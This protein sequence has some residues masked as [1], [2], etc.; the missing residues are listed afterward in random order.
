[1]SL[2]TFVYAQTSELEERPVVAKDFGLISEDGDTLYLYED[3][4]NQG[5][6]VLLTFFG[7]NCVTCQN[8][9]SKLNEIFNEYNQNQDN[10]YVWSVE[11][12]TNSDYDDINQFEID[13]NAD[14]QCWNITDQD[15]VIALYDVTYTPFFFVICPDGSY[16]NYSI[17]VVPDVIE[18]CL[19]TN[20]ESIDNKISP[21]IISRQNMLVLEG[22]NLKYSVEIF[23]MD[24][25]KV[26]KSEMRANEVIYPKFPHGLYVYRIITNGNQYTGHFIW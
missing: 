9:V 14:Y 8:D 10:V 11:T 3:L 25:R 24:G 7:I 1:M 19:T 6:T 18:Y 17:D 26:M 13:Y 20:K 12:S 23:S 22:D 16:R 4:L 2:T 21:L 5:K 15:S